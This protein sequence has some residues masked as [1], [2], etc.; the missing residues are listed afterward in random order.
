MFL[1]EHELPCKYASV[2]AVQALLAQGGR[3][4]LNRSSGV[5]VCVSR[6]VLFIETM[7]QMREVPLAIGK[8]TL[9]PE[10]CVE[11]AV[12]LRTETDKF[13]SVH[14]KF[15]DSVL[16]Y[17]IIRGYA[18]LHTRTPGLRMLLSGKTHHVSIKKWLNECVPPA[19][20]QQVHFLSDAN[21]LLWAE[22]LGTAAHAAVTAQTQRMLVLRVHRI[23]TDCT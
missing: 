16:D 22:G 8:N 11:A 1:A 23:N 3:T 4:E 14:K 10:V 9:F 12:I 21:G 7:R 17:D 5:W 6:D 2:T 13:S 15:T 20:R 18:R 19:K